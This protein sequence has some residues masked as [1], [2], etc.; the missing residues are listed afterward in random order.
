MI[1]LVL[2]TR[3]LPP[4][5]HPQPHLTDLAFY[6]VPPESSL[7]SSPSA[8]K[9]PRRQ[10]KEALEKMGSMY[11]ITTALDCGDCE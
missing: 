2:G 10:A 5:F 4:L 7:T 8:S 9:D 6:A 11:L 3:P 1:L